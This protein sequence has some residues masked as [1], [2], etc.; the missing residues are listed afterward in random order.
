MFN[1][2]HVIHAYTEKKDFLIRFATGCGWRIIPNGRRNI[3]CIRLN[4]TSYY[5]TSVSRTKRLKRR[6]MRSW[7]FIIILNLGHQAIGVGRIR[8]HGAGWPG[9]LQHAGGDQ[10]VWGRAGGIASGVTQQR[11][12]VIEVRP[13]KTPYRSWHISGKSQLCASDLVTVRSWSC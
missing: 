4:N 8:W 2:R 3:I 9:A 5:T 7:V 10:E 1:K 6:S 12:S 13:I 11:G